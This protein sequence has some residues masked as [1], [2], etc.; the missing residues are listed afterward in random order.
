VRNGQLQVQIAPVVNRVGEENHLD[1]GFGYVRI[2]NEAVTLQH[3]RLSL[4][5]DQKRALRSVKVAWGG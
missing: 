4:G 5:Y 2:A 1:D 3:V